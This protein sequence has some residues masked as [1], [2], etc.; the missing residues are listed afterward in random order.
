MADET[1]LDT[2]ADCGEKAVVMM[3]VDY[4]TELRYGRK[5]IR[6]RGGQI[7]I[8]SRCWREALK[9]I[10]TPVTHQSPKKRKMEACDSGLPL[11][12]YG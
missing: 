3:I 8:C 6:V 7:A 5:V 9:K 10:E 11:S 12:G 4:P 2:C 1:A